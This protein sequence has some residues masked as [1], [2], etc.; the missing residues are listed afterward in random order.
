MSSTS[1][2]HSAPLQVDLDLFRGPLHTLLD[3]IER[4]E[5]PITRVSLV[6]VTDQYLALVRGSPRSTST[7]PPSSCTWRRACCC[8]SR[9]RCCRAPTDEEPREDADDED[10]LEARLLAYRRYRERPACSPP[11]RRPGLRMFGR[12]PSGRESPVRAAPTRCGRRPLRLR[13]AAVRG[14]A[15]HARPESAP[16]PP[17]RAR[18]SRLPTCCSSSSSACAGAADAR[19]HDLVAE[20]GDVIVAITMFLA[21]LELVRQ[22]RLSLHQE[23]TFGPIELRVE[24]GPWR[25]PWRMISCPGSAGGS[26][27]K[28]QHWG[29]DGC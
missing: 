26:G 14:D 10:D 17:R 9:W 28:A 6:E 24:G 7:S 2:A 27:M 19:F 13:R 11:A 22:R 23:E 8:S 15:A 20:A 1:L 16:A 25:C 29:R 5:L 18:W 12:A 4:R 3:L 21:V